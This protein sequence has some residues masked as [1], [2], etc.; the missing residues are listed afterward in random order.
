MIDRGV[1]LHIAATRRFETLARSL[2]RHVAAVTWPAVG[3]IAA[4]HFLSSWLLMAV[5]DGAP[6]ALAQTFWYYYFV[7]ATTVGYGD[8]APV[9]SAGRAV[10]VFWIMPGGIAIFTS[11][12]AKV[13]QSAAAYWRRRML[14]LDDFSDLEAHTV[15]LGWNGENTRKMVAFMRGDQAERDIVLV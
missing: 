6:I 9:T 15:I 7:T 2:Y 3:L 12:I 13:V 11:V 10:A 5:T 14:G 1:P 4:S 8:F